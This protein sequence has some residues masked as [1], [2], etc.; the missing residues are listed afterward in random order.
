MFKI[1][2]WF[3][4]NHWQSNSEK[5]F[6][7][8]H[9]VATTNL[10]VLH[11]LFNYLISEMATAYIRWYLPKTLNWLITLLLQKWR[12]SC[13]SFCNIFCSLWPSSSIGNSSLADQQ[14]ISIEPCSVVIL[15]VQEYLHFLFKMYIKLICSN[16]FKANE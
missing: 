3:I 1:C 11:S 13:R 15:L 6:V 8:F 14:G 2:Q 10:Q 7:T 16:S 9:K 5:H 12:E 4:Q